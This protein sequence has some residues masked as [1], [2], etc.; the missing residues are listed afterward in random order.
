MSNPSNR[1]FLCII[2]ENGLPTDAQAASFANPGRLMAFQLPVRE[3][4][5]SVIVGAEWPQRDGVI[6]MQ[7]MVFPKK[8]SS[9]VLRWEEGGRG[10]CA[11]TD[12]TGR[13]SGGLTG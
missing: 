4:K 8:A 2:K 11:S 7:C 10:I 5:N 3:V 12:T 9:L 6:L 1:E 13:P